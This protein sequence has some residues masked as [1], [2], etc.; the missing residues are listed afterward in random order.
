MFRLLFSK[1]FLLLWLFTSWWFT[2]PSGDVHRAVT[3]DVYNALCVMYGD[4]WPCD[5]DIDEVV[6]HITDPDHDPDIVHTLVELCKCNNKEV[7]MS[8]C[9]EPGTYAARGVLCK[10]TFTSR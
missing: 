10:V 4:K 9:T 2:L 5:I 1:V 7:D 6:N 8:T 3:R